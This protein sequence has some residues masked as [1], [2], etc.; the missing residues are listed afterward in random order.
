[1]R[2]LK[3]RSQSTKQKLSSSTTA[4]LTRIVSFTPDEEA[5]SP[6]SVELLAST[7]SRGKAVIHGKGGSSTIRFC[8]QSSG[9]SRRWHRREDG[10]RGSRRCQGRCLEWVSRVRCRGEWV[11]GRTVTRSSEVS[12]DSDWS[13]EAEANEGEEEDSVELHWG[14][15]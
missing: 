14:T 2:S 5:C 4:S 8:S 9:D 7:H 15:C 1:M 11:E 13:R 10:G 12:I 3:G 6:A